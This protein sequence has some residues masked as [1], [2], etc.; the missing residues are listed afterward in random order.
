MFPYRMYCLQE[1]KPGNA[2]VCEFALHL[3]VR[4]KVDSQFQLAL[5][6]KLFL[7]QWPHDVPR[8]AGE[9]IRR[10]VRY[11]FSGMLRATAV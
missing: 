2:A 8:V 9:G 6:L 7:L 4:V 3:L 11:M 5:P 1:L 10:E